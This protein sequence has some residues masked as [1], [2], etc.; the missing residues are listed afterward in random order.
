MKYNIEKSHCMDNSTI[1]ISGPTA[2]GKTAL[3]I[4]L[5]QTLE[6]KWG[7]Q[8]EIINADSVQMYNE[9]KI[10][11]AYPSNEEL[12]Q[13]KHNLFGILTPYESS[14]VTSWLEKANKE[15][16]RIHSAEKIAIVCGGTGFYIKALLNGVANIPTIPE[17]IREEVK[18]YFVEVGRDVFFTKLAELD[19]ESAK[20]LHKN[21]TQRI[22]RA[23]EVAFY[24]GKPLS[25]WWKDTKAS[26]ENDEIPII[27]LLPDKEKIREHA[28]TRI[29]KM[30][31]KGAIEEVQTFNEKY[32]NYIGP[33][34]EVIGYREIC[35]FIQ[36]K[37]IKSEDELIEQIRVRTNQYIKR[38]STWFRNKL[39]NAKF[40]CD[41][42]ENCAVNEIIELIKKADKRKIIENG[43]Y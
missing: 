20:N 17:K 27:V 22:L 40:I 4:K 34:Q 9:L 14:S 24:T 35:N 28:R 39:K 10:L 13:V 21:D 18:K 1:I 33:L 41:F 30:I 32:P 15:L 16:V 42:G 29:Y 8:S 6:M 19:M 3:A 23:Y 26:R 36:R 43:E 12:K 25:E 38:Q 7:Y 2:S 37:N 5:A 31:E 11:T